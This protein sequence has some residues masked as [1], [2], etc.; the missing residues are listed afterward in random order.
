MRVKGARIELMGIPSSSVHA[1][2]LQYIRYQ[3]V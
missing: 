3:R 2:S 1:A